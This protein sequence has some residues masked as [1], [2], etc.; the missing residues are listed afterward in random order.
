MSDFWSVWEQVPS[1]LFQP[2]T[3]SICQIILGINLAR[4]YLEEF[5][6]IKECFFKPEEDSLPKRKKSCLVLEG[7]TTV[8]IFLY[9]SGHTNTWIFRQLT[10]TSLPLHCKLTWH[11][12]IPWSCALNYLHACLLKCYWI[13][14]F[15]RI[16]VISPRLDGLI[17]EASLYQITVS[18]QLSSDTPQQSLTP[19]YNL[20]CIKHEPSGSF[21]K[22]GDR[23]RMLW[24]VKK[25]PGF[26]ELD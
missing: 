26:I 19:I 11:H 22:A 4:Y 18:T 10:V 5:N 8:M 15:G 25:T 23:L 16:K 14:F 7:Q 2:S 24:H 20:L 6:R 21:Y 17:L 13:F 12:I 3:F 9:L 1:N